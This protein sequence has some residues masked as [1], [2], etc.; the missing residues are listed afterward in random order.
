MATSCLAHL[1]LLSPGHI[2]TSSE[3]EVGEVQ[4]MLIALLGPGAQPKIAGMQPALV[5]ST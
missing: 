1:Y 3:G 5:H 4:T 2:L